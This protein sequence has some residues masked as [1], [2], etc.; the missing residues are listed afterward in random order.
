MNFRSWMPEAEVSLA[1]SAAPRMGLE[2]FGFQMR[3]AERPQLQR[4]LIDNALASGVEIHWDRA[5][6]ALEQGD[7][8]VRV[9]FADGT[10]DVA[11]F[12]VGCD[13][14]HSGTRAM[15]F[16]KERADY[17]GCTQVRAARFRSAGAALNGGAG[18]LGA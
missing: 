5:P 3:G 6:S 7:D 18:R 9:R 15:L 12:V 10:S 16:G 14:I 17:T 13:G 4:M 8:E 2:R 1:S 11:S